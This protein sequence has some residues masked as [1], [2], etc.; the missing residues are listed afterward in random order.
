MNHKFF[1]HMPTI[2]EIVRQAQEQ[3]VK[4]TGLKIKLTPF[5]ISS[6]DDES[7]VALL[8]E[9]HNRWGLQSNQ[10]ANEGYER[11]Y[12]YMRKIFWMIARSR[13]SKYNLKKLGTMVG[14]DNHTSVVKG[15]KSGY[16]LLRVQD[17]IFLS[18]YDPVKDLI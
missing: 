3:I 1:K 14:V 15:I 5:V 12:P 17:E 11:P 8:E 2:I 4:E 9:L 16:D 10:L 13:C 18:V 6:S 7:V